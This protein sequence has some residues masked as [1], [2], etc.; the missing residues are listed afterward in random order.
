MKFIFY[1]IL[2]ICFFKYIISLDNIS[3]KCQ[4]F[5][6]IEGGECLSHNLKCKCKEGYT[7]LYNEENFILCNY[8]RSNK[9]VAGLIEL[10]FGFGFGHFYSKRYL[11]GSIQF[12]VE[13]I[14]YCLMIC[15][16]FCFII[17]DRHFNHYFTSTYLFV[18]IYCPLVV[19]SIFFWQLI[20][21]VLFF[22]GFYQDG[23]G[24][25]LF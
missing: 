14:S 20:D 8:K 4:E 6:S 5:C 3:Q 13:V 22:R 15:L 24:I 17:Y 2:N 18:T 9:F 7:T 10:F 25:D 12:F 1:L 23:N 16:F 21:S 19:V 11:Y